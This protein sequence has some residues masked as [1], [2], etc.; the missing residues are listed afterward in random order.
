M[1][2]NKD[3]L[4]QVIATQRP[5]FLVIEG[6]IDRDVLKRPDFD[7]LCDI[8]EAV[9]I[10]GVR[11]SGKSYLMRLIWHA[12][13]V[14]GIVG[15]NNF[16]S[17]NFEDEK[18]I[19]FKA[20]DFDPLLESFFELYPVDRREKI[21]LF[22]DEIQNI[23]GWEKFIRRLIEQGGYKI[24]ITGSNATLLSKELATSLTG[25]SFPL[26]LY[27]FSFGE[28]VRWKWGRELKK[29][30]YYQDDR[31]VE[32]MQLFSEYCDQGG[33]PEVM[34]QGFRPILQEY[35]KD[36]VYRDIVVRY[37]IRHEAG[38]RELAAFMI[39][40]IGV[41]MSLE[42]IAKMTRMKSIMTVKNYL[43]HLQNTYLLFFLPKYSHSVKRQIYNPDKAY[44]V[45]TGLYNEV[46]FTTSANEGRVL[47][48]IVCTEL[49]RRNWSVFYW[50]NGKSECDFVVQKK[51]MPLQMIQ[52][53]KFLDQT[54]EDRELNGLLGAMNEYNLNEGL[55]LTADRSD[56]F[57]KEGKQII[58]KPVWQWL[59][60]E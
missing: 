19:G 41:A 21:Y 5:A 49:L 38:L 2:L 26:V 43:S 28:F 42:R 35:W 18:L 27:P 10:T 31:R 46:A 58:I 4:K 1:A 45:D 40:N 23:P 7:I 11:R 54:N 51:S 37:R 55:I 32:L 39:A 52:V 48:N 33:F 8:R 6:S 20:T 56:M 16:L 12:L 9:V 47:E 30:D 24:F 53:T 44:V 59:L 17:V 60:E 36:I 22:F 29:E 50:S 57:E 13:R 15:E 3:I 14:R 25:R 34:L